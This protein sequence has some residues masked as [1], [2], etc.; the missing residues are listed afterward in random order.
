MTC[1][2]LPDLILT[3]ARVLTMDRHSPSA[4]AV[5]VKDGRVQRVGRI[6]DISALKSDGVK[7]ID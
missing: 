6:S 2:D 1:D 3:N 4:E 7:V 5:A